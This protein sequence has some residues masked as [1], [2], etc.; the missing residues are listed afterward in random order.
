VQHGMCKNSQSYGCL[1]GLRRL[2]QQSALYCRSVDGGV[3]IVMSGCVAPA[4]AV[5]AAAE[6]LPLLQLP[7]MQ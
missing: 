5:V 6:I 1:G 2:L 4:T 7:P 3:A